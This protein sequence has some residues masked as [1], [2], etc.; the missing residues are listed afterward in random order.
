MRGITKKQ[1]K[2]R[3]IRAK[4][5][6]KSVI[7]KPNNDNKES[8]TP[9][10]TTIIPQVRICAG[11]ADNGI[12]TAAHLRGSPNNR[13]KQHMKTW[14]YGINSLYRI[15]SLKSEIKR[16]CWMSTWQKFTGLK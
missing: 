3:E 13:D 5:K 7:P 15:A 11:A 4:K 12:S 2:I 1:Y 6:E 8:L 16:S 10:T 9:N 14:S